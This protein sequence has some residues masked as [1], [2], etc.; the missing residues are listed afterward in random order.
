MIEMR[1]GTR[2]IKRFMVAIIMGLCTICAGGSFYFFSTLLYSNNIHPLLS[3]ILALTLILFAI[4]FG[5]VACVLA[6]K[7]DKQKYEEH[8]KR[9]EFYDN[10][11]LMTPIIDKV[12]Y[13]QRQMPKKKYN[14]AQRFVLHL[15]KIT[16][17]D[18]T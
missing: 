15:N 10:Q 13:P 14:I 3:L 9:M 2:G 6:S 18:S 16:K 17:V 8:I 7:E 11:L 4:V 12:S 5:F 1:L